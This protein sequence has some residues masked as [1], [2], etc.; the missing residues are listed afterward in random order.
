MHTMILRR[1]RWALMFLYLVAAVWPACG[2]L[3]PAVADERRPWAPAAAP[4]MTRW[5]KEVRPDDPRP[6]YP[7][8]TAGP[9]GLEVVE[10]PVAVRVRRPEPGPRERLASGKALP[11]TILVPF[12][13]EAALSGIGKGTEVHERV[14]YRR[15]F[16]VP[17]SWKDRRVLLHFGAVDWEATVWVN[18]REM[19]AHRAATRRSRSTSPTRSRRAARAAGGRGRRVRPGRPEAGR[20]PA[21]RQAAGIGGIW[22]TRTT[23]IW[24]SVWIEPVQDTHLRAVR[25]GPI[26]PATRDDCASRRHVGGAA[27]CG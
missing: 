8:P 15:T 6:E 7:P 2:L 9:Q 5:A 11:E 18:G 24:Q 14:W 23:G 17:K 13:F 1:R 25:A 10:R 27:G 4:L 21:Q 12:T 16:E 22:Y 26:R 19:G 20:V 3:R